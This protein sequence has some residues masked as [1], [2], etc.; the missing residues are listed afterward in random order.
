MLWILKIMFS[1][2]TIFKLRFAANASIMAAILALSIVLLKLIKTNFRPCVRSVSTE[3]VCLSY[4]AGV[5]Y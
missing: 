4:E 3:S 2:S 5:S 1:F